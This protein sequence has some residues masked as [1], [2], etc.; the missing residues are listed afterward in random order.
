MSIGLAYLR[1][2]IERGARAAFREAKPDLFL[3]NETPAYE[4]VAEHYRLH[5]QLPAIATLAENSLALAPAPEPPDYYLQRMRRRAAHNAVNAIREQFQQ[6]HQDRDTETLTAIVRDLAYTLGRYE[7]E[8]DV[9]TLHELAEEV[10]QDYQQAAANPGGQ[11]VPLGW[12]YLNEVL[13]GGVEPGDVVT[14]VA[15]PGMGK[16]W[17]MCHNARASW[18]S[19]ASV[20]FVSMEM[21]TKQIARRMLGYQAEINPNLLKMGNLTQ[22]SQGQ[23]TEALTYFGSEDRPPFHVLSGSFKSSVGSVDAA[24][25]EFQPDIVYVDASYLMA[26]RA[27]KARSATWEMAADVGKDIKEMAMNRG[28][29][30]VQS[31]QF[32]REATKAK[33]LDVAHI[34]GSDAIGQIASVVIAIEPGAAPDERSQRKL[35]ILKNRES[36]DR[37][38]FKIRFLFDP[39]TFSFIPPDEQVDAAV[40]D[41]FGGI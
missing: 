23:V 17:L 20:L 36:E 31:V 40:S 29:P 28:V 19:G 24:I 30:I 6:A 15:R 9:A 14:L 21:T 16:S 7:P 12:D 32:N 18:L 4:F 26:P 8:R 38:S 27:P 41:A 34:G 2:C 13:R 33:S 3:A 39:P 5:G 1:S 11:F 10:W 22:A 25:Q 37:A 35:T